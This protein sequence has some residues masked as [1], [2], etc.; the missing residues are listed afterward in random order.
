MSSGAIAARAGIPSR[1]TIPCAALAAA[2]W[3]LLVLLAAQRSSPGLAVAWALG[4][5]LGATLQRGRFC[6]AGAFRDLF[7]MRNGTM[8]RAILFGL[9]LVTPLFALI[10]SKAVPDPSFGAL[11]VGAHVVPF[12]LHLVAGGLVFGI[13]MV[14]A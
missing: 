4:L 12:G 6:F 11:P 10:E 13:G 8:M 5:A 9:A 1:P 2:A 14:V 7:L 3:A